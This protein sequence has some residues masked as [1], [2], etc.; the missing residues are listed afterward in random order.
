MPTA[1]TIANEHY[2]QKP[3]DSGLLY[4]KYSNQLLPF[5]HLHRTVLTHHVHRAFP[6]C[7]RYERD[8]RRHLDTLVEAGQIKKTAF[9]SS[10]RSNVY[11]ITQMGFEA[12]RKLKESKRGVPDSYTPPKGK[13]LLHE[14]MTTE[15]AVSIYEFIQSQSRIRILRE[16]RFELWWTNL[17]PK[18][19]DYSFLYHDKLGFNFCVLEMI[20]GEDSTQRIRECLQDYDTFLL[21][22]DGQQAIKDLYRSHG[23]KNPQPEM[24]ILCVTQNR[25][26]NQ[27]ARDKERKTLAQSFFVSPETQR[28][29]WTTNTE[30]LDSSLSTGNINETIW[31]CGADLVPYRQQ[32]ETMAN[33]QRTKFLD[34]LMREQLP[35]YS[36][37]HDPAA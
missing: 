35:T 4:S 5:F 12:Y 11:N 37:F 17:L 30:E 15:T 34:D 6:R 21:S 28:R 19:P 1:F 22:A 26:I 3:S 33:R 14:L 24:R 25:N 13:D 10:F 27:T 23:A 32:W 8:V 36:L 16:D 2:A 20:A 31:H 7:F 9:R 29:V 18:V